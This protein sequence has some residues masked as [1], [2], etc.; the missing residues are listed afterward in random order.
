MNTELEDRPTSTGM[1]L[2]L[3]WRASR[4]A[5]SG[6]AQARERLRQSA[7]AWT[8]EDRAAVGEF[9]QAQIARQQSDGGPGS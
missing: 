5:P 7:D 4:K 1:R 6:L 3:V 8:S 9:L 2:R